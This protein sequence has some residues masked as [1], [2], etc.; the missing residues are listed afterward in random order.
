M[1]LEYLNFSCFWFFVFFF[2]VT[3]AGVENLSSCCDMWTSAIC[4]TG[5]I[6]DGLF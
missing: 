3:L 6:V 2:E 4:K 1:L 5:G